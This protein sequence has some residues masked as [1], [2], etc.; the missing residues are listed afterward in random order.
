M[1]ITAGR[2]VNVGIGIEVTPGTAVSAAIYPKWRE[3]SM[4]PV[5]EKS[6]FNS[7]RG[8]RSMSS[9][10][11]IR[12][13]YGEGSISVVPNVEI[14]PYLLRLALGGTVATALAGG[15]SAVWDHTISPQ[16][17]NASMKTFTLLSEEGA[18]VTEKYANGVVNSLTLE[19]SD[20]W[21]SMTANLLSKFPASGSITESFTEE[22]EFAYHQYAA[23]FGT[24]LSDAGGNSATPLKSISV[25]I[26]NGVLLDEAFLSGSNEPAAGGFVAGPRKVTGSYTLHFSDTTELAKYKANTVN[27]L[28][29]TFTGAQIG[30]AEYEKI[31]IKLPQIVLTKPPK[32]FN[33]DGVLVLSQEFE[34]VY[35]ATAGY[36]ITAVVTNEEEN[37]S[38][39]TY[40]PS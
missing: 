15:E 28:I 36:D 13:K 33:L 34:A 21:A 17:T 23:Q 27:A 1:A 32:E 22:T 8:V 5:S 30:T 7:Q 9:G 31:V 40:T 25:T 10:S 2:Q 12:R 29:I 6:L 3:F 26:D 39:A 4:N 37:A 38:G 16:E 11:M 20:D 19:A 24:D 18:I 14:A 35:D